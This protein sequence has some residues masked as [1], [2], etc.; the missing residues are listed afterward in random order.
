MRSCGYKTLFPL[1]LLLMF[2]GQASAGVLVKAG[3]MG[4]TH[5]GSSRKTVAYTS[6]KNGSGNVI[7]DQLKWQVLDDNGNP[8]LTNGSLF[9]SFCIEVDTYLTN[10]S[11]FTVYTAGDVPSSVIAAEKTNLLTGLVSNY[12]TLTDEIFKSGVETAAFQIATWEILYESAMP[13]STDTGTFQIT[14]NQDVRTLANSWLAGLNTSIPY[15]LSGHELRFLYNEKG[16]NQFMFIPSS[17][18][19]SLTS[20]QLPEPGAIAVWACFALGLA[21]TTIRRRRRN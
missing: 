9:N 14:N 8:E 17:S 12:L 7:A 13:L 19:A 16:Q 1:A 3:F 11:D 4:T 5:Q 20:S 15:S 18:P 2:A 10:L 6:A 21:T